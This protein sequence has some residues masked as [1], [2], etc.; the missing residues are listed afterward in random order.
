[1][2][3][4]GQTMEEGTILEWYRAEGESVAKGE[5]LF[6]VES[7]KA[8]FDIESPASGTVR[9]LWFP[10]GMTTPVLTCLALIGG[11]QED[12]SG[13]EPPAGAAVAPEAVPP[14]VPKSELPP[15]VARLGRR[16]RVFASPRARRLAAERRVDLERLSG[17]GSHGSIVERDVVAYLAAQPRATPL[18]RRVAARA[19]VELATLTGTGPAGRVSRADVEAALA[20]QAPAVDVASGAEVVPLTG[21][22]KLIAQ[23]MAE[24]AHTTAG[25]TLTTEADATELVDIVSRFR[26]LLSAQDVIPGYNDLLLKAVGRALQD[27][28]YL[29]ARWIEEEG[30]PVAIQ[31]KT[32]INIGVAIDTERGLVVPVIGNVPSMGLE[33]IARERRALT[34]RAL[35]GKLLPDDLLGGTFTLTNLGM[36]DIDAFTPLI[37]LPECAIL[38]VG[39]IRTMPAVHDG[40]ICVRQMMAL[41]LTFDHRIVD[42]A[43]AARF[44]RQVKQLVEQPSLLLL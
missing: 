38:G 1:M 39:R 7:D 6:Q 33:A 25:L 41:S 24:S 30:D 35:S 3:K 4:M 44:L 34:E 14:P 32:D 12:L 23:R 2:P 18:A 5:P 36:F 10:E 37:N 15:A 40:E 42:G 11:P 29:N 26:E 28:P 17:T 8:V 20:A 16:D 22:R 31:L 9:R 43:P 13:Y 19:G 27:H 21:V